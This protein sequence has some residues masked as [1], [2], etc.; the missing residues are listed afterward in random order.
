MLVSRNLD[1]QRFEDIVEAAEGRLPWLCPAWTDYNEHDPGITILE[2]MAWFKESQQFEMNSVTPEISRKLLELAGTHLRGERA[3]E[4]ALEVAPEAQP[5]ARLSELST[6]EG[7][8]FELL[9]DIP[10][11]RP[12]MSRIQIERPDRRGEVDV[13]ELLTGGAP[14]QPFEFGGEKGTALCL[15]FTERPEKALRLWFEIPACDG[16]ARNAPDE[17]TEPPRTLI[18]ELSGVGEVK[19]ARDDTLALSWSGY[20]TLPLSA[21]GAP[22]ADGVRWL[23][24]RQTEAGCEE[25]V[26]LAGVSAGRYRAAQTESRARLHRFTVEP[27]AERRVTIHSAQAKRAEAAVFVREASGWRQIEPDRLERQDGGLRVTLDAANAA[28]DGRENLLIACLDSLRLHDLL[29]DATGRPGEGFRLNLQGKRVLTDRLTLMCQTLERDGTVRPELWHYVDDLSLYG[30]RDRVFAYDRAHETVIVGDG[31]HGAMVAAGSGAVMVVEELVSLCEGGNIPAEA[32]LCFTEDDEPVSNGAAHGGCGA[33]SVAEGRGRLLRRLKNTKKCIAAQ[34]YERCAMET[35]GVRM[36]GAKALP[37][38]DVRQRHQK[39]PARVSVAVLPAGDSET[40]VADKRFLAAVN[41]QLERRRTV[42]IRAEAI[43]VRYAE[44]TVRMRVRGEQELSREA[45]EKALRA[46]FAARGERIGAGLSRDEVA[47]AVQ[48]LPGVWQA[49][50]VELRGIDQNSY[51][52]AG[53]DLTIP[54]DTILHPKRVEIEL[55]K[56]RR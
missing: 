29:F 3:A 30:P 45:I 4:C 5:R 51:Q 40:P 35:P 16:V 20:V 7:V 19:P 24:L 33:E 47:A 50:R 9:E 10:R 2:L 27:G 49:D 11:R 6:P 46:C 12:V 15:G 23:K 32:G 37:G 42:C 52:T 39:I 31:A 13:S 28:A 21:Q 54:P 53:G 1:D 8:V 38:Y 14:I 48:K 43:P 44:F 17:D 55:V 36:A 22:D 41:R 56:D 18:W 34:D 26:R 25:S